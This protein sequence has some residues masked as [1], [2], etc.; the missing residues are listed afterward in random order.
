L[1]HPRTEEEE[2]GREGTSSRPVKPVVKERKRDGKYRTRKTRVY[3]SRDHGRVVLM[4]V[5]MEIF[6]EPQRYWNF[7]YDF[8]NAIRSSR[9]N[10]V[11]MDAK[12]IGS[13]RGTSLVRKPSIV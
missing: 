3:G 6:N 8:R 7:V 2:R 5:S 1:T 4:G 10:I 13:T 12:R 11:S 9:N